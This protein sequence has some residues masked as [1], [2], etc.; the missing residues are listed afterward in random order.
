MQ[1]LA[2]FK[3]DVFRNFHCSARLLGHFGDIL[4]NRD[5]AVFNESL[6]EQAV[7][8]IK[9]TYA[10][11]DHLLNNLLGLVGVFRIVLYLGNQDFLFLVDI[12]L[13][14]GILVQIG[15]VKGC[16]LHCNILAAFL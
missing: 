1:T 4:F 13:R 11:I 10:A 9:L 3:T 15:G 12:F 2:L 14:Y 5:I 8:F 16:N 7:C 6:I